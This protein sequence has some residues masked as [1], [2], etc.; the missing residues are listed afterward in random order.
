MLDHL[1]PSARHLLLAVLGAFLGV[2]LK[3]VVTAHTVLGLNWPAELVK[4]TDTAGAAGAAAIT[5]LWATPLTRQYGV[6][7]D[8]EGDA[9]GV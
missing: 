1:P 3:D 8:R 5:A 4:A 7:A 2:L 9:A 6:G